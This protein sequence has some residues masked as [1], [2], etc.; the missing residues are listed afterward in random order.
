MVEQVLQGPTHHTIVSIKA[1]RS[2]PPSKLIQPLNPQCHEGVVFLSTPPPCISYADVRNYYGPYTHCSLDKGVACAQHIQLLA[3]TCACAW[4]ECTLTSAH[5]SKCMQTQES[6]GNMKISGSHPQAM[7]D[8][9]PTNVRLANPSCDHTPCGT[10]A[11]AHHLKMP[12]L[13]SW[14]GGTRVC[15]HLPTLHVLRHRKSVAL[16]R[17]SLHCT[18]HTVTGGTCENNWTPRFKKKRR[19]H[20]ELMQ[21][22]EI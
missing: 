20:G 15:D 12:E 17:W 2:R 7:K 21:E 16:L 1:L 3:H 4:Y 18:I 6:L 22:R 14:E 19:L 10:I 9:K 8:A 13:G 11:H 5:I